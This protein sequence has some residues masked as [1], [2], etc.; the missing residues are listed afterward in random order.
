VHGPLGVQPNRVREDRIGIVVHW[1]THWGFIEVA[2]RGSWY[3]AHVADLL[4]AEQLEVG[5]RVR[6][7]PTP[8]SRGP[9]ALGVELLA[10]APP[11]AERSE[12]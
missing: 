9:R 11:A 2:R 3:F 6:F 4:D 1:Q 7:V 8:T 10:P 5:Q 12:K